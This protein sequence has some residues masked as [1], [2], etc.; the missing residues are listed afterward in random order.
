VSGDSG[1][2]GVAAGAG[3]VYAFVK[4]GGPVGLDAWTGPRL[5]QGTS[6]A[7][8]IDGSKV[9]IGTNTGLGI[10]GS[11][12]LDKGDGYLFV[13]R[14]DTDSGGAAQPIQV[15]TTGQF[16]SGINT[17]P[18]KTT[19]SATN[20]PNLRV[21]SH[22]GNKDWLVG[23]PGEGTVGFGTILLWKTP[24]GGTA[25]VNV[26]GAPAGSVLKGLAVDGNAS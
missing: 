5:R 4:D 3:V 23:L 14:H 1:G 22:P 12:A 11:L 20:Q 10:Y 16:N 7:F 17:T 18:Y 26:T 15:F 24:L 8:P 13:A 21:I 19:G 25:A 6:A 2:T 9:I